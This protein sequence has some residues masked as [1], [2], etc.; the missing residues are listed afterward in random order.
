ME[1]AG[2]ITRKKKKSGKGFAISL[3]AGEP[4]GEKAEKP[5]K[6][7]RKNKGSS[8]L[9]V[10]QLLNQLET[11]IASLENTIAMKKEQLAE[12]KALHKQISTLAN[13]RR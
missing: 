13:L 4:H 1:K 6:Q 8:T 7:A 5:A 11:E 10:P 12:K 9:T 3:N 2:Y